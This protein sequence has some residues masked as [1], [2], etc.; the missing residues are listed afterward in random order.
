MTD[1]PEYE[2]PPVVEI[3]AAIQFVPVP[4][5][6]MREAV[7]V[8]RAFEGWDVVDV[9][10]ALEPIVEPPAGHIVGPILRFGLGNPPVRVILGS[11]GEHWVAQ[12]QQDRVVAHERKGQERPSFANVAPKLRHV[13]TRAARALDRP[14]LSPPHDAELVEVLYENA[15]PVGEGWNDFSELHRV[16]R[17]FSGDAGASPFA[18]FEQAQVGFA[19]ELTD[20]GEFAGRLRV[21]AEPHVGAD[22]D[23]SIHLRLISRRIVNNQD[24]DSVLERCHADIV[25][26]FTAVTTEPM[27]E[28]WGRRK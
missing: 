15:L 18:S 4:Q 8:S 11:E 23:R 26:G 7:A 14:L 25:L 28:I 10:S 27:H 21:I 6:G 17:V 2:R 1:L 16:L 22:G 9:A 13:A 12:V 19:Y 24:L 5:F 20:D 3:V